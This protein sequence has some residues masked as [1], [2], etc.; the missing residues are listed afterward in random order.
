MLVDV[1]D[2]A[3]NRVRALLATEPAERLPYWANTS[4]SPSGGV[5]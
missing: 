4:S 1:D 5:G 3:A 2:D